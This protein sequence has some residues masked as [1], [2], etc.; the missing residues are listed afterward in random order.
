ML[1]G[2]YIRDEEN[3]IF[4]VATLTEFNENN[5]QFKYINNPKL[6]ILYPHCIYEK[7]DEYILEDAFKQFNNKFITETFPV[8][9]IKN[10]WMYVINNNNYIMEKTD[11]YIELMPFDNDEFVRKFKGIK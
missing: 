11:R 1:P 3:F 4:I 2:I 5:T 6:L 10:N 9:V 8:Y 7:N